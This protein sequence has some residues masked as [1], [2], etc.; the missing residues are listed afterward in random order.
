MLAVTGSRREPGRR[1]LSA[2]RW[3]LVPCWAKD[4]SIGARAFNAKA[5]TVLVKPMF[6]GAVESQRC[7]L[8]ADAFYE[9]APAAAG[10]PAPQAALVLQVPGSGAA[11]FGRSF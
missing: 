3:G 5:E 1:R 9:W 8:P 2:F 4:P 10:G 7:V 11:P 6:R